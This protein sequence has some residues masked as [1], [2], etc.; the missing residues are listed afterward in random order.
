MGLPFRTFTESSTLLSTLVAAKV[1]TADIGTLYNLA[2]RT[3]LESHEW[4]ARRGEAVVNTDDPYSTGTATATQDSATVAGTDTVW[5]SSMVG[6]YIRVGSD[7]MY[8]KITAFGST[9]S[10][11]I[12]K[13]YAG[14]TQTD[15]EYEIFGL[16]YSVDA[17]DGEVG[18]ILLPTEEFSIEERSHRWVDQRDAPRRQEGSAPLVYVLH[19]VDSDGSQ[20]IEFWPR[21]SA[22]TAVRV[23]F[24]KRVDDLSGSSKPL[25]R[26]DLVEA[27]ALQ[28]LYSRLATEFGDQQY[29]REREYWAKVYQALW[30]KATEEDQARHGLPRSVSE[31]R[32]MA[33]DHDFYATHDLD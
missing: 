15:A 28:Y 11:T 12:E 5:T 22:A 24:Y 23:P 31:E 30:D 32:G 21:Y 33:Y 18:T 29:P 8:Y 25:I 2:Y 3:T 7:D 9:T 4:S 6:R 10:I 13:A 16:R 1:S 19:G 20:I 27:L 14:D 17:T 26:S